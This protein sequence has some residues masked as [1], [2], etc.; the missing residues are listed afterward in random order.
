[1][2]AFLSLALLAALAP[3]PPASRPPGTPPSQARIEPVD[4]V[5]PVPVKAPRPDD[6]TLVAALDV[7]QGA[8]KDRVSLYRDGTL[9][10][11]KTYE[12][13]RTMKKKILSEEEIDV[14]RRVCREAVPL[15]VTEYR[16]DVLGP[17]KPRRFRIEIGREDALPKV[18]QFDAF[19]RV[20]LVLGRTR[21]ALEELLARFDDTTISHDDLWDPSKLRRGDVLT[22][23]KD[24]RLY[25]VDRDDAFVRSLELVEVTRSLQRL[26]I[27]REDVPKLFLDPSPEDE[28]GERK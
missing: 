16:V 15:D 6:K 3:E 18:F 19:S 12:G 26:V 21:G 5:E 25:R 17:T 24:G 1:M 20:P 2:T 11:V 27:L 22:H 28:S 13:V 8:G 7:E 4:K 10:L 14:I 23:R 9:V